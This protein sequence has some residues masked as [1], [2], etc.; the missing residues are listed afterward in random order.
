MGGQRAFH[1]QTKQQNVISFCTDSFFQ[2]S[3]YLPLCVQTYAGYVVHM[4]RVEG[5]LKVGQRGTAHV[6]YEKRRATAAHHTFTHL[7]NHALQA[8]LG[9]D[10]TQKGSQ[11]TSD[12]LRFDFSHGKA[13]TP[14]QVAAV[15]SKVARV[16]EAQLP[17][18][19]QVVP[20]E[21]AKSIAGLRAVF[22]ET[23]PDPVR[24]VSVSLLPPSD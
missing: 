23:Y 7:L 13:L 8:E 15:E 11:V 3:S 10:V 2:N 24:V 6:D 22:G 1:L 18:Y 9:A 4:C 21:V 5:A 16:V 12:K 20:L 19:T 14:Q 17:V